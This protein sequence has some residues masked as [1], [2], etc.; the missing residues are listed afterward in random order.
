MINVNDIIAVGG[1]LV[2]VIGI[3]FGLVPYLKRKNI[4]AEKVLDTT[5][6][7]LKATEPL[8]QVAKA[9]PALKPA[10]TLV[11]WIEQKA[12]AGVKAAE[13]LYHAGSLQS[14]EEKFRAAQETVYAA[15][16]EID[17]T[18]TDNQKKLID[19]FIQEAVNDLGHATPTE[20]ER[21]AQIAKIQHE[22]AA[23]QAE[24]A[25]LKQTV[26]TI[27]STAGVVQKL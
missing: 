23:A 8:I 18:P 25:Q 4:N 10:A 12:A 1:V 14:N 15:L 7:V 26:A 3:M 20:A 21:N 19:D 5:G 2:G 16:K 27:Q 6:D 13:Q 22:L 11:D 9:I 17:V 24:N